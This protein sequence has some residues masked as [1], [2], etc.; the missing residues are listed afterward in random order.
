MNI[1]RENIDEL[2]AILRIKLTKEDYEDKVSSVL[3]DYRK[4]ARIDGFRPGKVPFGLISKMYR[5][6]I[7]VEEINKI[8]SESITKYLIDE[9]LNIL[10]DPL[11]HE[12]NEKT[13]DWDNDTEFDFAFDLGIA[14]EFEFSISKK[15]KIPFYKIKI[16]EPLRNK[17]IDS[18]TS[19]FGSFVPADVTKDNEMLK[20]EIQ[21][22]D[23]DNQILEAG[24]KVED[25]SISIDMIKDDKA[26]KKF[27]GLKV[28]DSLTVDIKKAFPNETDLAAMLKVDKDNLKNINGNFLVTVRSISKYKK[29]E[30]NAELWD[31]L[32]GKDVVK[33]KEEFIQRIEEEIKV[34]I[35]RDGDYKFRLDGKDILLKKFKKELP[36]EFLKRWIKATNKENI[37]DEQL[38]EEFP[39]FE[40]DLKWQLIKDKIAH[41]NEISVNEE[42]LVAFAKEFAM[43]QFRQ[44]G[45]YDVPEENLVNYARELLKKDEERRRIY[46][47][48]MEDKV[49]EVIKNLVKVDD[50]DISSEKFNKMFDN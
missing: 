9:K 41:D 34:G 42:E 10:G 49:F 21:Q 2:N 4:K 30:V 31:K 37:T 1:N 44:Y 3:K 32:Y 19:R 20:A 47:K 18:Y 38:T 35:E 45:L 14:P 27:I 8:V 28:N 5:K 23:Q 17:Y 33:S 39:H 15:D 48:K 6:P 16:D 11:P 25:A 24:I 50:K 46:D 43:M 29:A 13:I 40:K 12:E 22:L 26:K 36:V 7:L